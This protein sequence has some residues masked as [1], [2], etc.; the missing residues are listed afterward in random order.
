MRFAGTG[1]EL[2]AR[3]LHRLSRRAGQLVA[4]NVESFDDTR[5]SD[6]LFGRLLAAYTGADCPREGLVAAAAHGALFL[7]EIGDLPITSQVKLLRLLQDGG[8]CPLGADCL[9]QALARVIVATVRAPPAY[10]NL[11]LLINH[12]VEKAASALGKPIRSVPH[13]LFAFS[14]PIR[15]R[16]QSRAQ[17]YDYRRG[18]MLPRKAIALHSFEEFLA[19]SAD[20]GSDSPA[21][22]SGLKAVFAGDRI[23]TLVEAEAA[24][25]TEALRQVCSGSRGKRS[26]SVPAD[27]GNTR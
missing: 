16:K 4:E 22:P 26:T 7:D 25:I 2:T 11:P 5:F 27:Q 14:R 18:G 10:V 12:F 13:G 20:S 24:L 9:R 15:S 19:P 8:Y 1:E 3:A 6:T 23:P 17:G 21:A